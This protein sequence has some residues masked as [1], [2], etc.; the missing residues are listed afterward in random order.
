MELKPGYKQTELGVIPADWDVVTLGRIAT[1]RDGSSDAD[2][3]LDIRF[4]SVEHVTSGDFANDEVHF[5][6]GYRLDPVLS[7]KR[8]MLLMPDRFQR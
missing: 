1:I 2:V 5:Q 3:T 8:G 7:S 4:Y 6:D